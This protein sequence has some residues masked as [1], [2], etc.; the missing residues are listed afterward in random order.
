MPGPSSLLTKKTKN[1]ES[2]NPVPLPPPSS[3]A[4]AALAAALAGLALAPPAVAQGKIF[5]LQ[6][7]HA[8][9]TSTDAQRRSACEGFVAGVRQTLDVFKGSLK[10]RVRYCIP[11]SV[12]NRDFKDGFVAWA[13]RNRGEFERAAVRA[14]IKSAFERYPCG[15]APAKPFEF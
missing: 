12:S 3:L 10:E 15:N 8:L 9:C 7:L 14:V 13:E 4:R 11:A 1:G 5:T 6:E 2:W